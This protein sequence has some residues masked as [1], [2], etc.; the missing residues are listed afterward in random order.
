MNR[1]CSA[2]EKFGA[3]WI[4]AWQV[5]IVQRARFGCVQA[6]QGRVVGNDNI[7]VIAEALHAAIPKIA[8]NVIIAAR[9]LSKKFNVPHSRQ[10]EPNDDNA[11]GKCRAGAPPAKKLTDRQKV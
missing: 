1:G 3:R 7:R 6:S 4:W 9:R 5:R 2:E 10:Y 11:P 8:M